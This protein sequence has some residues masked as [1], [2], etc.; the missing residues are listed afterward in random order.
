MEP[1]LYIEIEGT[2]WKIMS[3]GQW[4]QLP[5]S[6]QLDPSL[7]FIKESPPLAGVINSSEEGEE[8]PLDTADNE[9]PQPLYQSASNYTAASSESGQGG[10]YVY[11][12]KPT[13]TETI[14]DAG[15]ETRPA[16][17]NDTNQNSDS[18]VFGESNSEPSVIPPLSNGAK[19]TLLIEDGGDGYENQF[20]VP[21]VTLS[22]RAFD[23]ENG[24]TVVV[25][26]T[27]QLGQT[28]TVSSTV[29]NG[30]WQITGVNL[31]SLAEGPIQ[32][33]ASVTD[34][35]GNFV[36]ATDATIK[37]TLAEVT[38]EFDGKGDQYLN[39]FEIPLTDLQGQIT[40]VEDGQPVNITI[41]DING[42]SLSF[43]SSATA[44]Q[45]QLTDKNLTSLSDGTLT[46]TASATDI[47]G[48][49]ATASNTIIKDTQAVITAK[50]DGN[51]D[52]YLNLSEINNVR[53]YGELT[54]VEDGQ[55]VNI[56]VS[57]GTN[58]DLNF[59]A[60]VSG[61]L[62]ETTEDLSSLTD[63]QLSIVASTI[64]IAGNPASA[65]GTI[66]VDTVLPTIDIDTL[67]GFRIDQ[68][69]AG[70]LT[71]LQGTSTGEVA[72]QP[73][74]LRVTDGTSEITASGT[75]AN[76]GSWT[77]SGIDI[78]S[79]DAS[80]PWELTATV[81]D[82]AG[83][84]A[85]DD[86]P[87]LTEP[88]SQTLLETDL[89]ASGRLTTTSLV[90]IDGA[91]FSFSADQ[92][93]LQT[94][95][96][97]SQAITVT[98]SVSLIEGRL[99]DNTLVFSF[100][101]AN[102][103]GTPANSTVITKL[104][105]SLDNTSGNTTLLSPMIDG[106]QTD[107]DTTTETVQVPMLITVKDSS[108][109]A[110]DD[111]A[112]VIEG[113]SVTG[114]V[115]V[116]DLNLDGVL[117]IS[118]VTAGGQTKAITPGNSVSFSLAEGT[119]VVS[120]DGSWNFASN[121]NLDHQQLQQAIFDYV[122]IGTGG[123]ITTATAT[124]DILDGEA[125]SFSTQVSIKTEPVLSTLPNT[126][127]STFTI[128]GGSDN[129][130]P[131]SLTFN[132]LTL[133]SLEGL[134]LT[135]GSSMVPLEYTLSNGGT[136]LTARLASGESVFI[137]TLSG[138]AAGDNLQGKISVEFFRPLDHNAIDVLTLPLKIDSAD[139]DG[140]PYPTGLVEYIYQ[141]GQNPQ[142][143]NGQNVRI[144][145][146]ELDTSPIVE[147]GTVNLTLG[148]DYITNAHFLLAEQPVL[149][150]NGETILYAVS[151]SGSVLTAHTG[152]I[153]D[154]VFTVT[155]PVAP[156]A[157]SDSSLAYDFRLYRGLDQ[158]SSD[159]IPVV[160]T[161]NDSDNDQTS[162]TLDIAITDAAGISLTAESLTV[163]EA[164]KHEDTPLL[165]L[166]QDSADIS[167]TAGHDAVQ[168]ILLDIA[169][170]DA[171]IDSNSNLMTQ[172]GAALTWRDN[173]DG[174]YD[175][176]LA[177]GSV[178][179][180]VSLPETI[181]IAPNQSATLQ[182][183][184]EQF[185]PVDHDD[186]GQDSAL[187]IDLPVAVIDSD[188][189][190]QSTTSVL[191]IYDGRDPE[192]ATSG[193]MSID[194]DGLLTADSVTATG[195]VDPIVSLVQGSDEIVA[196][197]FDR[198]AFNSAGYSSGG[199]PITLADVNA[200]G[201]WVG[202]TTGGDRVFQVRVNLDGTSE[203]ELFLPLD[204]SAPAP[205]TADEN[206]LEV[207]FN[208]QA[209]DAD[210]DT[211]ASSAFSVNVTDAVPT[212][213]ATEIQLVEGDSY[214]NGQLPS[215]LTGADGGKILSFGYRGDPAT[216]EQIPDGG[217]STITLYNPN[218]PGDTEVYGQLT[219]YSDGRIELS[220]EADVSDS[221]EIRESISYVVEDGD[222]DQTISTG[223]L[224]LGD[225]PGVIRVEDELITEDNRATLSVEVRP[226]DTDQGEAVQELRFDEASLNG[227]TLYLDS[228]SGDVLL[229]AV[230][231]VIT[232]SG[233]QL[234]FD[235]NGNA[236]PNG[237]LS[238]QPELHESNTTSTVVLQVSATI[239]TTNPVGS[240]DITGELHVSVLP[241]AD[242]PQW[243]DGSSTYLY[244]I[245]ED[246]PEA[247]LNVDAQLQ[248]TD[249]SETLS[250]RFESI[251]SDLQLTLNGQSV[252]AG[253]LYTQ[254]QIDQIKIKASPN[255]AGKLSFTLV[256]VATEAGSEFAVASDKTA[257]TPHQIEIHVTPVADTPELATKVV[258]GLEDQPIALNEFIS[259][260]LGDNDGS[261]S[262]SYRIEV[263]TGW[264]V[265]GGAY[266]QSPGVYLVPAADVL[267]GTALLVPKTDISSFTE[268]LS[269][270]VTAVAT[271]S[272]ADGLI[273][274]P[275]TAESATQ[276]VSIHLAGV[277]DEPV[278][279]DGGAG[280]WD[281]DAPSQTISN[282]VDFNEDSLIPLDF[283]VT[284]SDDDG[285]EVIN[286][287]LTN[288]PA[289]INLVDSGGLT[290]PLQV[291]GN[292]PVTGLI[293][294]V[295][296]T[297]LD[298]LY[299]K[300]ADDFSGTID[301]DG[302][303]VSTEPD[304]DTGEFPLHIAIEVKPIVDQVDGQVINTVGVEDKLS[305]LD[306]RPVVDQDLDNSEAISGFTINSIPA[307]LTLYIDNNPVGVVTPLDLSSFF[308][309]ATSS[310]D[311]FLASGRVAVQADTDLSGT[312]SIP[313]SYQVTD[314]SVTGASDS[315][316]LAGT[317]SVEIAARVE[318]DTRLESTTEVLTSTD[319]SPID[320]A[321]AVFFI[322]KDIDGS[323]YLEYIIIEVP[324]GT[325]FQ[326][327]H[328]NGATNN[329]NEWFI[330]ATGL[331]S[332]SIQEAAADLLSGA[333]L[334]S[335]TDT[336]VVEIIVKA[337]VVDGDDARIIS[338]PLQVQITGHGGGG[339]SCTPPTTPGDIT[340]GG[341]IIDA[342][343]G[344]PID[345]AGHLS[346]SVG[347][348]GDT[349]S[350]YIDASNLPPGAEITGAGVFPEYNSLGEIVGYTVNASGIETM[351]IDNLDEDFAG[352]ITLPINV[353]ATSGC[354]GSTAE[355]SQNIVIRIAPVVDEINI[356]ADTSTISEDQQR[357]LNLQVLLGDSNIPGEG[358][359]TFNSLTLTL[360]A[361]AE[362]TGDTSLFV[363]NGDGTWT[364]ND[365]SRLGE[366]ALK[367]PEHFSG[368][369]VIG[370]SA[371]ITDSVD[372]MT[373]TQDKT[374]SI[375]I[376]VD[377][378]TDFALLDASNSTGDEDSYIKLNLNSASLI[379]TDGSETMTLSI[380]GVPTGAVLAYKNGADY[381][382]LPNNGLDGGS[383][384]GSPTSA[385][386]VEIAQINNIY[387]LPAT[388]FSGD[389]PLS[390]RAT[391]LET[392]T[393]DLKTISENFTVGVN[394]IG[395][396]AEFFAVPASLSGSEGNGI[397]IPVNIRSLETDSDEQL[398]LSVLV[399][400]SSDPS[401]L[402]GLDRIRAGGVEGTFAS[403]GAGGMLATITIAASTLASFELLAG[404]AF[405]ELQVTLSAYTID[406]ALVLGSSQQDTGTVV[407]ED[408][409]ITITPYPDPPI[410]T[411]DYD[412]IVAEASGSIDLGL[413]L[414]EVNPAAG[415]TGHLS[416]TGIPEGLEINGV[417]I[418][419]GSLQVASADVSALAITGGFSGDQSFILSLTPSSTLAGQTESGTSVPLAITLNTVGAN[420][421][422]G[423]AGNDL[424][425]GGIDN[426]TLIGGAGNDTLTGGAGADSFIFAAADG[427]APGLPTLDQI[428][429]FDYSALSD[430]ID[431]SA[432]LDGLNVT[433]GSQAANYIEITPEGG[434][435][436]IAVFAD[437]DSNHVTHQISLN[438]VT[439]DN[440]YGQDATGVSQA[441]LLQQ[442]IDDQNLI[443]S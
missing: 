91:S 99:A 149:T 142:A 240:R 287:L 389:I 167:I 425:L 168:S 2:V 58:P 27:D 207:S 234:N 363:D 398:T 116:N 373:D 349:I 205:L 216:T 299:I 371:N 376:K 355:V 421:L 441:D 69:K 14:P 84:P 233:A 74:I 140:T 413:N 54:D 314:T 224:V 218:V 335:T 374:G 130:D 433:T 77:V 206:N 283:I 123:D 378:V 328:P 404:D 393:T 359:E 189:S 22:G 128:T 209:V 296:N 281:Y 418:S 416:I 219:I 259:G 366:L 333:T 383:F 372:G 98:S 347:A 410:L 49:P 253:T 179:F 10:S 274:V 186:S 265:S 322:D 225:N 23:I 133:G 213:L 346:G 438:G 394:P 264:S 95:T 324:E 419:G 351:V 402:E 111:S 137:M 442:M 122:A 107:S 171:V 100:T 427:G 145:E 93:A 392:G 51:G 197:T 329:G 401:A 3:D 115:L 110:I 305:P 117:T 55:R 301:F 200:D 342:Q 345:V 377:P 341:S 129:P 97:E 156:V 303:I 295:N 286:I 165:V 321:D 157:D 348:P 163:S 15:F 148:S 388:D 119:L 339:G 353:I 43:T 397:E 183:A 136:T 108:P 44:G 81:T 244:A 92:S 109:L 316:I 310:W 37:D 247:T 275:R 313:V 124:I 76:D 82:I 298:Q 231:G 331:T 238:Y 195:P 315:K 12:I 365:P 101:L 423:T 307:G 337:R 72:L 31:S 282:V 360:P 18:A 343:E 312:F 26:L 422:T 39:Q 50:F 60:T 424:V 198:S 125:G 292:D 164:P 162:V 146:S 270:N 278:I 80:Q 356:I 405:G 384:D 193:S 78:S 73:V 399:K 56:T 143:A 202:S 33:Y 86:M 262:L 139:L 121:R 386:G 30:G 411:Q 46:V 263:P 279:T 85:T 173:S 362:L 45:W 227:G 105:R 228:G 102:D 290:Y 440:L 300:T 409:T 63:G 203:F 306:L 141:D 40:H 250:Y 364:I 327:T 114:N 336:D 211:T 208:V 415:E 407:N 267:A 83:N 192:L 396:D 152:D 150:S 325:I 48:N 223:T 354:S 169:D 246:G 188:G 151:P 429:D 241:V 242:T 380:H 67:T 294:Q 319:G 7:P 269:I 276:T 214:S 59:M 379:D 25:T 191:T 38:A 160:V 64:D 118:S 147:S 239:T 1:V 5:P 36:D 382:L 248:D 443:T 417:A 112:E 29:Q 249:T 177:D 317:I 258:S 16:T 71:T 154:P 412:S 13:L 158:S 437:A 88:D 222:G 104:Y 320:L 127:E 135:S 408:L 68:F 428:K 170:G 271:E 280:H 210:G 61:G 261:E 289:G 395:D 252:L 344:Q 155:L 400:N 161:I 435:A 236:T 245:D 126:L 323:E 235:A 172:N 439:L 153:N 257:E 24:R 65:N 41:T 6:E 9:T 185:Q 35:F 194:E 387:L 326:I 53:L 434:S 368:D 120:S 243:Q 272:D 352:E 190:K 414:T 217:S 96:S 277:V 229:T 184:I 390:L 182:I 293:Y 28:L 201:W 338:T 266:E 284:T 226:G 196:V 47:A 334:K 220:T 332:D 430:R 403:D 17:Y 268:T 255:Y 32:G 297:I 431:V 89:Y 285:S 254:N 291:V 436:Q 375:T 432:I 273:P 132:E 21:S 103:P 385:W 79:L 11:S 175:A 308:D 134:T 166:A 180:T 260:G 369:L 251:P 340:G 370:V 90:N 381:I 199:S 361:G 406:S 212:T 87:T 159:L 357:V 75:V 176:L 232:L 302:T 304:G 113:Q 20:E 391:T 66:D 330:P 144:N 215:S 138:T 221:A 309:P 367:P 62:W 426:D 52:G 318:L 106:V 42:A 178:V 358:V 288:L 420:T 187:Q 256:A 131:A 174:S 237:T 34:L 94:L 204:H 230:G 57:D 4:V 181:D 19:L 70:T 350:F 311:E 8:A